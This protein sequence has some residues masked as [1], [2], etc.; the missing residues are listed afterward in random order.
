MKKIL[1]LESERKF[2]KHLIS[3]EKKVEHKKFYKE[4]KHLFIVLDVLVVFCILMN[5]GALVLTNM[6]VSQKNYAQAEITGVEVQYGEI[7]PAQSK[8]NNFQSRE[9]FAVSEIEKEIIREQN[10]RV[11]GMLFR[12]ALFWAFLLFAY[13]INRTKIYNYQQMGMIIFVVAFYFS[14]LGYDFFHDFGLYLG[15]ILYG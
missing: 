11:M 1:Q 5:F 7:N 14:I 15:K 8:I 13:I 2:L 3:N 12:Q 6:L 10:M 4:N 9:D